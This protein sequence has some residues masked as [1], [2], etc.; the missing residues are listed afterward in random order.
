M[1]QGIG[2]A[3]SELFAAAAL[4]SYSKPTNA[5]KD[6]QPQAEEGGSRKI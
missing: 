5:S 3:T 1:S 4:V 2:P 6:H